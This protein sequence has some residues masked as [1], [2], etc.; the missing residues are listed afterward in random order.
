MSEVDYS[1]RDVVS[2]QE[3]TNHVGQ[4]NE[5]STVSILVFEDLKKQ[6]Q[7]NLFDFYVYRGLL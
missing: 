2:I 4:A 6:D 7:K 5:Q 3:N 1:E